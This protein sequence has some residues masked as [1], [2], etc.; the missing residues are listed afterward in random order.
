MQDRDESGHAGPVTGLDSTSGFRAL[1]ELSPD[2]VFVIRSLFGIATAHAGQQ[3]SAQS[4]LAAAGSAMYQL[5]RM[6]HSHR[7]PPGSGVPGGHPG[8][9][10][11]HF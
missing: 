1:V 9:V 4:V 11:A 10:A 8:R 3:V 2:A 6:A 5:K 7:G